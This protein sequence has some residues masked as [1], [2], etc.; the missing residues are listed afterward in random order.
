MNYSGTYG[1]SKHLD[2]YTAF[3]LVLWRAFRYNFVAS[4]VGTYQITGAI[5]FGP[6]L[7]RHY[8]SY[9]NTYTYGLW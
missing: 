4:D 6:D 7:S 5:L 9:A 8:I 2:C 3:S 1:L